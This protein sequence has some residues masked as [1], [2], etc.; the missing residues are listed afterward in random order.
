MINFHRTVLLFFH[1][2][3]SWSLQRE[4]TFFRAI[5]D[6]R[7]CGDL[8]PPWQKN[9][10]RSA[11]KRSRAQNTEKKVSCFARTLFQRYLSFSGLP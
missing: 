8:C 9:L 6:P 7:E 2:N 10:A 5:R 3:K 1:L 4:K 11:R